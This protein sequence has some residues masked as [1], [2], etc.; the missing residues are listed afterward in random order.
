[1]LDPF[2]NDDFWCP[3]GDKGA[4]PASATIDLTAEDREA[5]SRVGCGDWISD[6]QIA[7]LESLG[8]LEKAFG[9]ALLTRLGRTVLGTPA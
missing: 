3:L 8:L 5:L 2:S 1:M 6:A 7:R 4:P 9:Q